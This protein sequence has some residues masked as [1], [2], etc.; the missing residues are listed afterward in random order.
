MRIDRVELTNFRCFENLEFD[1]NPHFTL[2]IGDNGSGKTSI[3]EALATAA[4][5]WSDGVED[6]T[7]SGG[8]R[9]P[10]SYDLRMKLLDVGDRTQVTYSPSGRISV[11]GCAF[12]WPLPG[13]ASVDDWTYHYSGDRLATHFSY[14]SNTHVVDRIADHLQSV[15]EGGQLT[16]PI[17][18]YY[19]ANRG[20]ES[21]GSAQ[22]AEHP[23]NRLAAFDKCMSGSL[24]IRKVSDWFKVEFIDRGERQ[25]QFSSR[26]R[27]VESTLATA[28]GAGDA[29]RFNTGL[30]QLEV[31]YWGSRQTVRMLSAGQRMIF[32]L[33]ADIAIK[34]VTQNPHLLNDLEPLRVIRETPGIVLIDEL[35]VHLHPKWQRGVA[36]SLKKAFPKIQ[37]VCTSHSPQI[38]GE[39]HPDEIRILEDGKVFTPPRSFGM[40]S[41]RVLEIIQDAE[42]R[43]KSVKDKL[44]ILFDAIE[45]NDFEQARKLLPV[46]EAELGEDDP[47]LS[48]AKSTMA[49]IESE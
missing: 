4:S 49:F 23:E 14:T 25:G 41:N 32:G 18:A 21:V 38:I 16:T 17:A 36:A 8:G 37:F 30:N 39:L 47:E 43:N 35:D 3:I 28:I 5:V 11:L 7:V 45:S 44:A 27:A 31:S 24:S 48:A 6:P 29:I 2:F 22:S 40:D 34:C 10:S 20:S 12:D 13:K 46:L 19:A 26:F 9:W 33:V 15:V 1:L 42:P